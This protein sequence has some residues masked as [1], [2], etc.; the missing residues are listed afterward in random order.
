[1]RIVDPEDSSEPAGDLE[2]VLRPNDKLDPISGLRT[3]FT[4]SS[5]ESAEN[6]TETPRFDPDSHGNPPN[7]TES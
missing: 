2:D 1:M 7:G 4:P 3:E 5:A 6:L